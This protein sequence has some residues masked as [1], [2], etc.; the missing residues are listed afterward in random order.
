M[1]N[2]IAEENNYLVGK[3]VSGIKSAMENKSVAE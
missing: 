2:K 1:E 3:L